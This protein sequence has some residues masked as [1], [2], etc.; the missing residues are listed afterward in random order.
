MA[1]TK[2]FWDYIKAAFSAKPKGMFIPPNWVGLAAVGLLGLLNPGIWLIGA[3]LEIGYLLAC[4]NNK[5]FRKVISAGA[6]AAVA[7][8]QQQTVQSI[9]ESLYPE[10]RKRYVALT[11]ECQEIL[12]TL[13]QNPDETLNEQ[14]T[15]LAHLVWISLNLLKAR[16][17]MGAHLRKLDIEQEQEGSLEQR[18]AEI[19]QQLNDASTDVLKQSLESRR[20]ILQE[21]LQKRVETEEKLA[22]TNAELQRIGDQVQLMRDQAALQADPAQ[23]SGSI[24]RISGD[25]K[26]A[27]TWINE[28]RRIYRELGDTLDDPAPA[29][30]FAQ[31]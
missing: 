20:A 9:F 24:D 30:I 23:L 22:F 8:K 25:L 3:G 18:I 1:A 15:G 27:S 6:E 16:G 11:N 31:E 19:D 13:K 26:E 5:R 10:D 4:A 12:N 2:S 29:A 28:Q 7:G 17:V 21:R 14:R